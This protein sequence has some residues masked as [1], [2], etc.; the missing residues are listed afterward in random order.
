MKIALIDDEKYQLEALKDALLQYFAGVAKEH[1]IGFSAPIEVPADINILDDVLVGNLLENA[2]E[3]CA[4]ENMPIITIRGKK[5]GNTLFFMFINTFT[6][7]T[8]KSPNGLYLSTKHEG[9]GIGLR[10]VR[11]I[12]DDYHGILDI[13]HNNGLFT[14]SVL[15]KE[16]SE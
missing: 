7:K 11:G 13:K 10:S 9:R 5:E 1:H 15:I 14:V 6:G 3:G 12:V 16:P 4:S 8:R 2:T